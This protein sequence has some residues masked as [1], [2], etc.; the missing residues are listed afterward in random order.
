MDIFRQIKNVLVI[1]EFEYVKVF[2]EL[3]K[4]YNSNKIK[5]DLYIYSNNINKLK[6][7]NLKNL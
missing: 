2:L 4:I 1:F 5:L 6:K 3:G 7:K